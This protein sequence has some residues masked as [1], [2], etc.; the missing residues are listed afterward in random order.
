MKAPF[1]R[2][3]TLD[4]TLLLFEWTTD[5]TTRSNSFQTQPIDYTSHAD[6]VNKKVLSSS[7]LW[8][9]YIVEQIPVGQVRL[10]LDSRIGLISFSIAPKY[11]GNGYGEAMLECLE[12]SIRHMD[13]MSLVG[14][15]KLENKSSQR[16]FEKLLY[17]ANDEKHHIRYSK[18][19][20]P[21]QKHY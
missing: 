3:V 16:I 18:M 20:I 15:V 21:H 12:N 7:T 8:Y 17:K 13:I 2:K 6:F 4:D 1:L 14:L 5:A 11:R 9:V 10:E 19:I